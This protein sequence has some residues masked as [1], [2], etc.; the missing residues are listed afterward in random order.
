MI[1]FMSSIRKH[2]QCSIGKSSSHSLF[3]ELFDGSWFT[4]IIQFTGEDLELV[5]GA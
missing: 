5:L 2:D 4:V 1:E 3:D